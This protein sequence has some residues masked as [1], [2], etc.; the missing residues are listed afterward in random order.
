MNGKPLLLA[1]FVAQSLVVGP[2]EAASPSFDCAKATTNTEHAIC[3]SDLLS[4]LDGEMA[5]A[6]RVAR[7]GVGAN[8][9]QHIRD[10]QISW[11]G[12]RNACGGDA[13]CIEARMRERIVALRGETPAHAS[14]GRLSGTYCAHGGDD[15]ILLEDFGNAIE[16][17]FV[18]FQSRGHSCGTGQLRAVKS[19]SAY[20][21]HQGGCSFRIV[22]EAGQLVFSSGGEP[23]CRNL[24]GA[25]AAFGRHIFPF[26]DRRPLPSNWT[27]AME[28]SGC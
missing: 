13:D 23:G 25:R 28:S 7:T 3:A 16:F 2:G 22:P 4:A 21:A 18:S 17:S 27:S 26:S 19:G 14:T 10:E 11:I 24:C 6:Y 12:R 5:D 9:R 8:A 1:F 15:V 20:T